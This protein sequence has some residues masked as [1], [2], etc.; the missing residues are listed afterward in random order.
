MNTE[1]VSFPRIHSG[2]LEVYWNGEWGTVCDDGFGQ[3]EADMACVELG[4]KS[5]LFYDNVDRIGSVSF[6]LCSMNQ[7]CMHTHTLTW[8]PIIIMIPLQL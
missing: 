6:Q 8:L 2:R 4:Y 7:F 5:A 3:M 1:G